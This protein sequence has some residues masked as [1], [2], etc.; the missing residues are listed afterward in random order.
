VEAF[1]THPIDQIKTQFQ[2]NRK[3]NGSILTALQSQAAE[4]GIR[5]LYRGVLAACLRPQSLFMYAGNEWSSQLIGSK[6]WFITETG[7]LSVSGGYIAGFLTGFPEAIGV[8]PFEVVKVRMQSLEHVGR[9]TSSFE[10]AKSLVLKEGVASLYKGFW[11]TCGRNCTFNCVYFGTIRATRSRFNLPENPIT[12]FGVGIVAAFVATVVKMPF[13]ITKSRLQ[14]QIS[15]GTARYNGVVHC[16]STV[17][18][19]EGVAG[20]YKGF[21]PTS[22]RMVLGMSVSLVVFEAAIRQSTKLNG[23]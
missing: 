2:V 12:D 21:V 17:L 16:M 10:C 8:T 19:E 23:N 11:A 13:D 1:A 15:G 18:R 6:P 20:L 22:L 14:N 5:R 7:N 4:G 3:E 9:Y